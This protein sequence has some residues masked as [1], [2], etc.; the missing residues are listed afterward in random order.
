M[1]A[2]NEL[3]PQDRL[4][5]VPTAAN[6]AGADRCTA[7]VQRFHVASPVIERWLVNETTCL[8]RSV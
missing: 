4:E 8:V 2:E 1:W 5:T 3:P 6:M 7:H